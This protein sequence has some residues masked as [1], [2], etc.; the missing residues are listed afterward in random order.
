[1]VLSPAFMMVFTVL[2]LTGTFWGLWKI[3]EKAGERGWKALIPFYNMYAWLKVLQR[4]A[5][6]LIFVFMPFLAYSCFS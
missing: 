6:W 1:M 5:W 2:Y 3:F 4:P